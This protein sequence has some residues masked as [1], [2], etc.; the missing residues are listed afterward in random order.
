MFQPCSCSLA[1][2]EQHGLEPTQTLP[3]PGHC[4]TAC[5]Q[6]CLG[7]LAHCDSGWA[8]RFIQELCVRDEP[9]TLANPTCL[10]TNSAKNTRVLRA[11][12]GR[13]PRDSRDWSHCKVTGGMGVLGAN[14]E[15]REKE[16]G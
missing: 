14:R 10:T 4:D 5:P 16:P 8:L 3:G 2:K 9:T 12:P 6:A 13:F 15:E 11:Q 1:G 7:H